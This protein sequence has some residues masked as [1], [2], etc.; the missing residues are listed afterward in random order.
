MANKEMENG[1]SASVLNGQ[2]N[3]QRWSDEEDDLIIYF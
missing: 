2:M 1:I 3:E